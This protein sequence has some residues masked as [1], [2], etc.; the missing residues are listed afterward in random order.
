MVRTGNSLVVLVLGGEMFVDVSSK[1][2]FVFIR[3]TLE[4]CTILEEFYYCLF[5]VCES[6]EFFYTHFLW[7]NCFFG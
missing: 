2:F 6:E 1:G 5:D 3:Q 4:V 7:I